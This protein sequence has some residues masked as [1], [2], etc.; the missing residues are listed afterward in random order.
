MAASCAGA[1]S[2]LLAISQRKTVLVETSQP[3]PAS[4][5]AS[6]LACRPCFMRAFL[7]R[8]PLSSRPGSGTSPSASASGSASSGGGV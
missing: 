6:S 2:A 1:I 5:S 7:S 4:R 3:R 8:G